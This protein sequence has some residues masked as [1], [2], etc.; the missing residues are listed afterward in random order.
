MGFDCGFD[1]Y[2][3]LEATAA[4]KEAYQR[5][6]EEITRTYGDVYDEDG[7]RKDGKILHIETDPDHPDCNLFL[8]FMVGECPR[9]P[10]SL[11]RCDY[12]LRFS[13]KVSGGLTA[14]AEP[15]IRGVHKIAKKYFADRVNFWHEM[16]ET[17]DAR[18]FGYYTWREVYD[19]DKELRALGPGQE[20][21]LMI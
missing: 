11:D 4:N 2:P 14:H 18:Q 10:R 15:Y 16:C 9:M 6:L 20:R 21:D 5:F 8:E 12:F 7:R 13:S 17:G 3:R 19:A 1:I